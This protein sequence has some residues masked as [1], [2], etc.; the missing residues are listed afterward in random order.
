[1]SESFPETERHIGSSGNINPYVDQLSAT[2]RERIWNQAIDME[3]WDT[4]EMVAIKPPEIP[5]DQII[6]D[7]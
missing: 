7:I 2:E 6:K 5:S 1:M 3:D 4:A